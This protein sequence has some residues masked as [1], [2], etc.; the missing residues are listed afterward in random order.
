MKHARMSVCIEMSAFIVPKSYI[1]SMERTGFNGKK[2]ENC[3]LAVQSN[4]LED[5]P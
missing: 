4:M 1:E 5:H 3:A 2:I